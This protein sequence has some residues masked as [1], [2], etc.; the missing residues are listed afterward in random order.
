MRPTASLTESGRSGFSVL[1]LAITMTIMAILVGVV[2]LRVTNVSAESMS[3]RIV[4]SVQGLQPQVAQYHHDTGRLPREYAGWPGQAFHMLS[5][6]AGTPGWDG[7]YIEA[8]LCASW[9]PSGGQTHMFNYI[10]DAYT[11]DDGFDL[12]GDGV[13][14]VQGTQGCMMTYWDIQDDVASQV[15]VAIDGSQA[16]GW[17]NGGRV[18]YQPGK[19]RLSILLLDL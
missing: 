15:D 8:P 6:D 13:P 9:N 1:E 19:R 10:V 7:P 12:N 16:E 14:D 4:E 17:R 18:E 5:E 2:S 3:A 11:N